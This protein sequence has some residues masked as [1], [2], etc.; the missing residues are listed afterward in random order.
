VV[1]AVQEGVVALE[2]E[3]LVVGLGLVV[4]LVG[5]PAGAPVVDAG[6]RAAG[7]EHGLDLAED[8]LSALIGSVGVDEQH[9]VVEVG[10]EPSHDSETGVRTRSRAP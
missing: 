2:L 3:Q 10:H 8:G 9:E 7:V 6:D 1:E 4:D 5:D